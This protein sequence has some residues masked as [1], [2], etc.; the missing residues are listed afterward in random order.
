MKKHFLK[1]FGYDKF[2]N[3][4]MLVSVIEANYP[5]ATGKLMAHLLSAQQIWL[6][7][8]KGIAPA[9]PVV[10]WPDWEADTFQQRLQN[11]YGQWTEYLNGLKD[12]DFDEVIRYKNSLGNSYD[13]KLVDILTHVINHGTHHRAQIGQQLKQAGVEKLPNTDYIAF[14]RPELLR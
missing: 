13:N 4:A 11:N 7:R 2:E 14:M 5:G 3:E 1:L 9:S 6:N 10:L 12:S 8:C